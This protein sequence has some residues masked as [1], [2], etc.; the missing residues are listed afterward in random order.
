MLMDCKYYLLEHLIQ[1]ETLGTTLANSKIYNYEYVINTS[2]FYW[3]VKDM[4]CKFAIDCRSFVMDVN[5]LVKSACEIHCLHEE[6]KWINADIESI[7]QVHQ[8]FRENHP[9]IKN[10]CMY[11]IKFKDTPKT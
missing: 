2:L 4:Q 3:N 8:E 1:N 7:E 9:L 5:I 11:T 6:N 10:F